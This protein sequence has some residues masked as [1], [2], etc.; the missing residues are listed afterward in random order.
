[1]SRPALRWSLVGASDIAATCVLPAIRAVGDTV[2]VVRSGNA[3][4]GA[5]WAR[6]YEVPEAVTELREAL[7]RDDVDAVYVSS[8]NALHREHVEAAAA[9]GKH[10]LAEKPLAL[11]L[12]DAQAMVAAC[13]AAGV[14]MATNHH[15]PASPTHRTLKRAV[16]EGMVGDVRAVRVHHAVQ[17]PARLA[18]WRIDDPV[19]GGVVLDVTVHDAAAVA[20]ILGTRAVEVT[21]VAL[22]QDN[23]ADGPF[24]AVMTSARWEG[25]VLVQTHDAYNNPHLPTSLHVLGTAGALV[26]DDCNT[27]APVGTVTLWRGTSSEPLDVGPRDDLYEVTVSAFGAAVHGE[28]GVIVTGEDGIDSLAYSHAALESLRTGRSIAVSRGR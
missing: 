6:Q 17:L 18:G 20:A 4:H 13:R 7:D 14:V 22:N 12:E 9:A 11:S 8:V 21:A 19:G 3:A 15:L 26:A 1:M 23:A 27:G 25:G 5:A 28:G 10:V 2:M 16:G 24:D